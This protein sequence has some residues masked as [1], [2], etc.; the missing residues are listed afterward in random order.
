FL[1][2]CSV[3]LTPAGEEGISRSAER[4]QRL[5]LWKPQAGLSLTSYAPDVSRR[6][7]RKQMRQ[8]LFLNGWRT[9]LSRFAV[10]YGKIVR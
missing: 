6:E 8:H 2:P 4:D 9:F 5:C 1:T 10:Y 3:F 7:T